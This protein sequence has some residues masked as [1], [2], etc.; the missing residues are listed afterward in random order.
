MSVN[1]ASNTILLNEANHVI[2]RI[3]GPFRIWASVNKI[4]R[5]LLHECVGVNVFLML[6]IQ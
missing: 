4:F 3:E 6:K 5:K 1:C 2:Q